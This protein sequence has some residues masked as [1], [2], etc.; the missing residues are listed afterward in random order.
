MNIRPFLAVVKNA[1]RTPL[2]LAAASLIALTSLA[3]SADVEPIDASTEAL[4]LYPAGTFQLAAGKCAG[5]GTSAQAFWYFGDDLVGVAPQATPAPPLVWL[6]AS[7]VVDGAMLSADR[8][9][10]DLGGTGSVPLALVPQLRT[11]PSFYDASSAEFLA[12]R[13]LRLRGEMVAGPAGE[14]RFVAR[15]VWPKDFTVLP[16]PVQPLAEAQTL[17]SLVRAD[18]GGARDAYSTRVLWSRG[19]TPDW[20]GK[21]IVGLMLNGA[22]GD[23]D[24][25]LGGHFGVVTGQYTDGSMHG[26]LVNNFYGIDSISEKGI[27][28]GVTPLDKYLGDLNSGQS[29]YRP[30]YMLVALLRSDEIPRAYQARINGVFDRLYKHEVEYDHA[31]NNCSGL[32]SDGFRALGWNIPARG[33]DD[34]LKAIPAYALIA[35]QKRSLAEGRDIYDYLTA[36]TTRLYPAVAFDAMGAD[37][38]AL[39]RHTTQRPLDAFEQKLA[40]QLEAIVFVRVPQ[41]PSSRAFGSAPVASFTEYRDTAPADRA[42]W[43]IVPGLPRPTMPADLRLSEAPPARPSPVPLPVAAAALAILAVLALAGRWAW[44]RLRKPRSA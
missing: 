44:R 32:A 24:E 17:Q 16:G 7:K 23:D 33:N 22:Q 40:D 25:S 31:N 30:S 29:W 35:A 37:L 15:T 1:H 43:K 5:C 27:V 26:W 36:E 6:G 9:H 39:A 8:R 3:A 13:P 10:L 11:N 4:G 42:K 34:K 38:L 41:F 21:A 12:R 18:G 14:T 19:P 2:P 20:R 28:A